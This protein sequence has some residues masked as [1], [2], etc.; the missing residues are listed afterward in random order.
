V[1]FETEPGE[2]AQVDFA[3]FNVVFTDEPEN[4]RIVRLFVSVRR[5]STDN[6]DLNYPA[7]MRG[8]SGPRCRMCS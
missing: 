2:Q 6:C 7:G 5:R 1:R 3:R 4:P 8:L